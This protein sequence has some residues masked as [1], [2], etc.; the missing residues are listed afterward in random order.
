MK[1]RY[2]PIG[3]GHRERGAVLPFVAISLTVLIAA[4]A[5]TVDIGQETNTNR[6]LQAGADAIALDAA[7]AVTGGTA[8][9]VASAVATAAQDSAGRNNVA[10]SKL[11]VD[12][13]T[14]SGTT[15]T[16][17]A[18]VISAGVVQT[19]N[20]ASVPSGVRVTMASNTKFAFMPGGVTSSRKAVASQQAITGIAVG[21]FLARVNAG[22][23]NTGLLNSIL[24]GYIGGNLTLVGYS[25]IAAGTVNLGQLQ[26]Q[27][28]FGTVDQLLNANITLKNLLN[29]AAAALSAKG[30]SNSLNARTDVMTIAGA[31]PA[32]STLSLKLGDLIGVASSVGDSSAASA[33]FNVLQLVQSAAQVAN[34]T[35]A[36]SVT[37]S[38]SSLG[39]LGSLLNSSGNSVS[40]KVIEAPQWEIGPVGTQVHTAQVRLLVHLRPLGTV[41]GG[42]LDL[43]I[44]VEVA[45]ATSTVQSITCPASPGTVG[46]HTDAQAVRARVGTVSDINAV[47]PTVTD[48]TILNVPLVASVTGRADVS[49]AGSA[50]DTTFTGPFNWS[51]TH[52]VGTTSLQLGNL[53]KAQ[54][55]HLDLN[56]LG[57]GLGL[58]SVLSDT[59][60]IL[61][62]IL[63][64]V[65][66]G[67]LDSVLNDLAVSMNIGGADVTDFMIN[68]T[69]LRLVS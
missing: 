68:C 56:V 63:G 13:G 32:N 53:I 61:N 36:I 64:A 39:G 20:S 22:L 7:R 30:D 26:A 17:V 40:L 31:I 48:A 44:Y 25:G 23:F 21:S 27:L 67:V 65:D 49:L 34:G 18:T 35:N 43:P 47:N 57:L 2:L 8:A 59:L 24:G 19:V 9:Q 55:L 28:G 51:N 45:S 1:R 38:P 3:R 33:D 12:L 15:F 66:T 62:P 5:L 58:G 69:P 29:A 46:V 52:T 41:L 54:P 4:T 11:T 14:V 16:T 37:L 6:T 10:V 60:N 50:N 42:V